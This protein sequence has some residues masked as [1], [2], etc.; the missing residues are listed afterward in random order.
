MTS[1]DIFCLMGVWNEVV[2]AVVK[3]L[4]VYCGSSGRVDETYRAAAT[5]FGGLM[6]QADIDLV[7]GGGRVGL[8]GLV[9]DAVLAGGGRVTGIIPGHLHDQEV[10]H[11]GVSELI[12]VDNMHERKKR[13]FDL[14]DA[15]VVLPGG[16]GTLDE[17]FEIVTWRQLK[18]HDKPL[19]IVNVGGYWA[20][21]AALIDHAVSSGF[22]PPH[23]HSF[24]SLVDDVEAVLPA[25]AAA[26]EPILVKR[27]ALV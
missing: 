18:L 25:L 22:A 19:I 13:M 10:G 7:Y 4:C 5:R 2:M 3:R 9:A 12:V 17:T 11:S 27:T 1:R 15:F 24:Y 14:S 16:L 21:L 23:A 8:M 6:A 20:P 26:P